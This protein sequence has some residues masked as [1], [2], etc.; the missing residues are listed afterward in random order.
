[1]AY[2]IAHA[3]H[4][5]DVE[6]SCHNCRA[7]RIEQ[8]TERKLQTQRKEQHY[9]TYLG[10]EADVGL[11]RYRRQISEIGR[12]QKTRHYIS[13]HHRLLE[14]LEQEGSGAT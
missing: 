4:A 2:E 11:V 9:D 1:M 5:E 14:P 13:E 10:P 8:L 12:R 6:Q 7:S 3:Y